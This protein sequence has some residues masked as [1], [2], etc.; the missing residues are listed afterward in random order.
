MKLR[1]FRCAPIGLLFFLIP[2]SCGSSGS[3]DATPPDGMPGAGTPPGVGAEGGPE[4]DA[5]QGSD[6]GKK[7][8][9]GPELGCG[10]ETGFQPGSPWPMPGRCPTRRGRTDVVGMRADHIAWSKDLSWG[11]AGELTIAADGTVYVPSF[12]PTA[13]LAL[14]PAN[15][16]TKWSYPL[17]P[18][19]GDECYA[20]AAVIGGDGTL[21]LGTNCQKLIALHPNGTLAWTFTAAKSNVTGETFVT[22]PVIAADGTIYVGASDKKLYALHPDGTVAWSFFNDFSYTNE[23]SGGAPSIAPDGTIVYGTLGAADGWIVALDPSG[24]LKWKF[25]TGS[26]VISP[27]AIAD[28]GTIYVGS[29]DK[30]LYA[31]APDG[32]KKWSY[33]TSERIYAGPSIA[34]DGTVYVGGEDQILHALNPNGTVKWSFPVDGD[35][36]CA[37]SIGGDGTIYLGP[38]KQTAYALNPDGTV[39]FSHVFPNYRGDHANV[40]IGAKGELYTIAVTDRQTAIVAFGP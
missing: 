11:G 33:A 30:N 31:L 19:G 22:T 34:A 15:G 13:L 25:H 20:S 16:N 36:S 29:E 26:S 7:N 27:A 6:A 38:Q 3:A 32:T 9:A 2:V 18:D 1:F 21:Y 23:I 8:D 5:A 14:D 4:N 39:L 24:A 10:G 17:A 37:P 28:D 12:N 40:A 35:V